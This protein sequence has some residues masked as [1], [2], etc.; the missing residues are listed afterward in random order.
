MHT[1][2]DANEASLIPNQIEFM[3][4]GWR[5]RAAMLQPIDV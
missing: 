1:E 5:R 3:T 4:I 2:V